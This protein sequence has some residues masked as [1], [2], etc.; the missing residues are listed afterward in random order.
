MSDVDYTAQRAMQ[1]SKRFGVIALRIGSVIEHRLTKALKLA[2]GR[3]LEKGSKIHLGVDDITRHPDEPHK[4]HCRRPDVAQGK[5]TWSP[6]EH[7]EQHP[8]GFA[9][10]KEL[11]AVHR[12]N[13]ELRN[14][15]ET[16]L[17][18]AVADLPASPGKK[19][20]L[21]KNG[22]EVEGAVEPR[23]ARILILSDE[24]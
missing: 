4:W 22:E 12:S 2:S 18:F 17:Y 20:V 14:D 21:D 6:C 15:E 16:H 13:R 11:L 5:T 3:L 24:E 9:T 23:G 8:E 1:K 10:K 7:M 19:A